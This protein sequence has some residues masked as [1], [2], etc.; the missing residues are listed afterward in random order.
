MN[1]NNFYIKRIKF[2]KKI[3]KDYDNLNNY[4]VVCFET[5][6]SIE[7]VSNYFTKKETFNDLKTLC[8]DLNHILDK[9]KTFYIKNTN[10]INVNP[11][12]IKI[13]DN[14]ILNEIHDSN[15]FENFY[16]NNDLESLKWN[17][18]VEYDNNDDDTLITHDFGLFYKVKDKYYFVKNSIKEVIKQI[19]KKHPLNKSTKNE[20]IIINQRKNL[21]KMNWTIQT[22]NKKEK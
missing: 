1:I 13:I 5:G 8:Y 20:Y 12:N 11:E 17:C 15:S 9:N 4:W 3:P 7:K 6:D 18:Q 19:V 10:Y 21:D 14:I 2:E 16:S 22:K